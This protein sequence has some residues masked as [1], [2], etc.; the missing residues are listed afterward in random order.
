MRLLFTHVS[1]E[2][3]EAESTRLEK[4]LR[5]RIAREGIPA[6]DLIGPAPCFVER[7]RGRYRWHLVLRGSNPVSVL[8]GGN[9]PMGWQVDVD[10][11]SLL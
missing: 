8:E 10:P 6:V 7:I 9:L 2:R 5:E 3:C 4:M 1:L 11:V